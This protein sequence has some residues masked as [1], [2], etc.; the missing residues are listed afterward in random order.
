M[1]TPVFNFRL[2][3]D[4]ANGLREMAKV[5][6]AK[7]TSDFLREMVGAMCS[8]QPEQIKAFVGRLI[9]RAGEQLTLQLTAPLDAVT[10]AQKPVKKA[11]KKAKGKKG[12]GHASR[13]S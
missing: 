10:K 5:Y 7:N 12:G 11:K 2:P 13:R 4:Q 1:A 8:G 6:G 9:Q 3:V